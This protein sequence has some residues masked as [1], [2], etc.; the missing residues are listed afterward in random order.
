VGGTSPFGTR[1]KLPL[2][3]EKSILALPVIF[4]NAGSRGLLAR[5]APAE[6]VRILNPTMVNVSI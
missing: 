1:K 6:V 2:Y 4:I 5:I 3:M